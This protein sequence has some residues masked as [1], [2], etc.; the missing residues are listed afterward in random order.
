MVLVVVADLDGGGGGG[1]GL[2]KGLQVCVRR[3]DL[4]L[5]PRNTNHQNTQTRKP[6][7]TRF[8]QWNHNKR[9]PTT[10]NL[11]HRLNH[12]PNHQNGLHYQPKHQ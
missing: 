7:Q 3:L 8:N 9:T 1:R 12:Q 5:Q 2:E 4:G 11:K 6:H 10:N